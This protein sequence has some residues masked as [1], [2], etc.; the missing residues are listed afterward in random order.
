V[1]SIRFRVPKTGAWYRDVVGVNSD[2]YNVSKLHLGGTFWL[3][4]VSHGSTTPSYMLE[5]DGHTDS[6]R[7]AEF[8][9]RVLSYTRALGYWVDDCI[10]STLP[11]NSPSRRRIG[12]LISP[13]KGI[14][15]SPARTYSWKYWRIWARQC[16]PPWKSSRCSR[17]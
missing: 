10:P 8:S 14:R 12:V 13:S 11:A 4:E 16:E 15:K 9:T 6:F 5:S 7:F 3:L 1:K 17:A 2:E